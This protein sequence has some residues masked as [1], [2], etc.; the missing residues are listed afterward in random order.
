MY[1]CFVDRKGAHSIWRLLNSIAQQILDNG[2]RVA[3]FRLDDSAQLSPLDAPAGVEVHDIQVKRKNNPLD[4]FAQQRDFCR[5]LKHHLVRDRPDIV[6]TNFCV[7][8]SAARAMVHRELGIPIVTTCHELYTSLNHYLRW[9]A[10]RTTPCAKRIVYISSTVAKSYGSV[11][12]A[13]GQPTSDREVIVPNGVDVDLIC[14]RAGKVSEFRPGQ[15][16]SVG[17]LVPEKGHADAIQALAGIIP[18][19]PTVRYRVIGDGPER[20]ALANLSHQLGIA[21]QVEFPG[22]VPYQS[23]IDAMA[24]AAIVLLPSIHE[25]FGLTLAEAICCGRPIVASRIP[26]FE[27]VVASCNAKVSFCSAG[28]FE[29]IAD[30]VLQIL[31]DPHNRSTPP[32]QTTTHCLS[33]QQMAD[34]YRDLYRQILASPGATVARQSAGGA[35]T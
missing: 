2:G 11:L 23:A 33:I 32:D 24:T 19:H 28:R 13:D 5:S 18:K 7:P 8:G 21:D 34:R 1:V 3:Y 29:S 30:E 16:V 15:I 27:E 12:G 6:H 4:L 22:W 31:G 17:R 14:Q 10:R 35:S 26:A 9:T 25:G 20:D